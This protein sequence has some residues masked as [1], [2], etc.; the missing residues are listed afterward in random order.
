MAIMSTMQFS[1]LFDLSEAE[2][3]QLAQDLWDSIPA[4]ST[5]LPLDEAQLRE[6]E[7]RVAD[8]QGDPASAISW[9]EARARLRERF[10]A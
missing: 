10:G 5:A 8:H 7:R 6:M 4:Q 1:E 2:R 9:E 3:I